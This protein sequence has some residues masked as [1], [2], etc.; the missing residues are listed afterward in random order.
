MSQHPLK[1]N[2]SRFVNQNFRNQHFPILEEQHDNLG[3]YALGFTCMPGDIYCWRFIV[4]IGDS[5][6]F[7]CASSH[8]NFLLSSNTAYRVLCELNSVW[9]FCLKVI[10]HW[11]LILLTL[12]VRCWTHEIVV[13]R[14]IIFVWTCETVVFRYIIFLYQ[15]FLM[16]MK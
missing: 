7:C 11:H 1:D 16:A 10:C 14:Y 12:P 8:S 4:M 5:C 15:L 13:F 2:L 6:L 9:L 3:F